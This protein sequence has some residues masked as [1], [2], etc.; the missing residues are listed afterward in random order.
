MSW[1]TSPTERGAAEG[2]R[3]CSSGPAPC[4]APGSFCELPAARAALEALADAGILRRADLPGTGGPGRPRRW[5]VA[6]E[7]LD[8]LT[9]RRRRSSGGGALIHHGRD[10]FATDTSA[11]ITPEPAVGSTQTPK[12]ARFFRSIPRRT[13]HCWPRNCRLKMS[14]KVQ[15]QS[16]I[17]PTRSIP[18]GC[19]P[20]HGVTAP[21]KK[22]VQRKGSC[23]TIRF[24]AAPD[25]TYVPGL[26]MRR[27]AVRFRSRAP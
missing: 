21:S 23:E 10:A 5:W 15:H 1:L 22:P 14:R 6:G 9:R 24:K 27:S 18:R 12:N 16:K 11:W 26:V 8:L 2:M 20:S 25:R 4:I 7:L 19:D 17:G 3:T 13:R